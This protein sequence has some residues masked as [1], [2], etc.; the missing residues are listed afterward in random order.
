MEITKREIIF[1]VCIVAIMIIIGIP[2]NEKLTGDYARDR[3]EY[4]KAISVS[5][6]KE[7]EYGMRTSAGNAFVNG[8][9]AAVKPVSYKGVKG[10]YISIKK[11]TEYY[12][13]HT[14]KTTYTDSNGQVHEKTEIYYSWDEID[15][16]EKTCKKVS[17]LGNEFDIKKID[18]PAGEYI[19]TIQNGFTRYKYYG[20]QE[21]QKGTI[22]TTLKKGTIKNHSS[23]YASG[24]KETREKL[25]HVGKYSGY[26]FWTMW[27]IIT[28][29]VVCLFLHMENEWLED[30]I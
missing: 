30:N 29:Y 5:G 4:R 19:D 7:F 10:K 14:R 20:V 17:F 9:L 27:F 12:T 23:F 8:E 24:L 22:Y 6:Q 16:E 13:K 1:S 18:I 2:I 15:R 3:A 11:I 21:K 25:E 28:G 26:V